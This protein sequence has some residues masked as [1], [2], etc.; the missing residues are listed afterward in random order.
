[1]FG[2]LK[3]E[4]FVNVVEGGAVSAGHRMHMDACTRCRETLKSLQSLYLEVTTLDEH[5]PE[6][7]WS[8]FR[9][10]VRDEMLS[11]SVQRQTVVRRWT[12]WSLRPAFAWSLSVLLAV[13]ITAGAFM[14]TERTPSIPVTPTVEFIT[15]TD[16]AEPLIETQGIETEIQ[17]WSNDNVFEDIAT[18]GLEETENLRRLIEA[19]G[20]GVFQTK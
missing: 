17:V 3:A 11:R 8:E 2:H 18:L 20:L 14:L 19:E 15:M 10:S 16:E 5:I 6:P 12:G 13:G 1:M 4:E 7:D 9:T